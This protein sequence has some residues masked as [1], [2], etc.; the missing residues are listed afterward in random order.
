MSM[1]IEEVLQD[2]FW[3][4]WL[5][6][7]YIYIIDQYRGIKNKVCI[8]PRHRVVDSIYISPIC[9]LIISQYNNVQVRKF[10]KTKHLL[11]GNVMLRW[12]LFASSSLY[13]W[14][15]PGISRSRPLSFFLILVRCLL[16]AWH[17]HTIN[18]RDEL[19]NNNQKRSTYTPIACTKVTLCPNFRPCKAFRDVERDITGV[20]NFRCLL[21][22]HLF[23]P[24]TLKNPRSLNR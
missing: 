3:I 18:F 5:S 20:W 23:L 19:I 14:Y 17:Y 22:F 24:E 9:V 11:Y 7:S 13:S 21:S 2:I 4:L 15:T 16:W 12:R 1:T 10:L 8:C 6:S